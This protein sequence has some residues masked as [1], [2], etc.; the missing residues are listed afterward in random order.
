LGLSGS[1]WL[2]V[3]AV[4]GLV[5]LNGF[6]VAAE[7]ALVSV[8]K[9]RIDQLV[10]EGSRAARGVQKALTHLDTYIAATQLGITM[11]S[12]ALGFVGEPALAGLVEP[13]FAKVLP[14]EGARISAHGVAVGV[15]FAIATAL[16]IVLGELAP[17]SVALQRPDTTSL[18]VTAPLDIF[19]K[20]FRP[21]IIFL[22][23]TGN[24]VVRLFGLKPVA[25]HASVHSVEELQ[26]LVHSTR[27]AGLLEPQ[28][29]QMVAGVFDF[30]DT[31][32]R[33]VMVP[34]LDVVAVEVESPLEEV[35]TLH[36]KSKRTRLPVYEAELDNIVGTA[37][38]LDVLDAQRRRSDIGLR[39]IIRP[40]FFVPETRRAGDL[41][42]D[43]QR[44]KRPMAVVRDEYGTLTGIVTVEDL[45]EEIVGEIN[46]EYDPVE[47]PEVVQLDAHTMLIDGRMSLV[48]FQERMG[49]AMPVGEVDTVGGFVF[50]LL[51]HQPQRGE[52]GVWEG[53][54]FRVEDTDGRRV[55]R[56]RVIRT[57]H[58]D[59]EPQ[60]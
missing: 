60:Q 28:Q 35:V 54:I 50:G 21:F 8:R 10:N 56:V 16:H 51:G 38:L 23:A 31:T 2:G 4:F 55:Q 5:L 36:L 1:P 43:L 30:E 52:S 7:F 26:L 41:L 20:V 58:G 49:I 34:R 25:E 6:F 18:W 40:P 37:N 17:K 47:E 39:E 14:N 12:L 32:A 27:E 15:A 24:M 13:H 29:E 59:V 46:D 3:L 53:L 42:A 45:L 44:H 9:S 33:Q 19:L 48:D 22:N 11:A 57:H